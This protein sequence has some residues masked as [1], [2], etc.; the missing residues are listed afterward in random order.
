MYRMK[1][2]RRD[3]MI[4]FANES[5]T[6]DGNSR[7]NGLLFS[8]LR[9]EGTNGAGFGIGAACPFFSRAI[10]LRSFTNFTQIH[11][12]TQAHTPNARPVQK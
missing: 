9:I 11:K 5:S 7:V 1:K 8:V 12:D 3:P 10:W 6:N 2:V 4:A